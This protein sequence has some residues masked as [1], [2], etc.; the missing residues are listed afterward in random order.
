MNSLMVSCSAPAMTT[1]SKTRI[2]KRRKMT[3]TKAT[4]RVSVILL[5]ARMRIV[6]CR[7]DGA[8]TVRVPWT[9]E[10]KKA[11]HEGRAVHPVLELREAHAVETRTTTRTIRRATRAKAAIASRPD[12][13]E[14]DHAL[15]NK[16][17]Q[18]TSKKVMPLMKT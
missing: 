15:R 13:A 6:E 7:A 14:G 17:D 3:T 8:R 12:G 11:A 10:R 9:L 16:N 2:M 5:T 1:L 18:S 4:S